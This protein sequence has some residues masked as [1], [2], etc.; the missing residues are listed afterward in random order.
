[1]SPKSHLFRITRVLKSHLSRL[2]AVCIGKIRCRQREK[3]SLKTFSREDFLSAFLCPERNNFSGLP[4]FAF[5][6]PS[7]PVLLCPSK[8]RQPS[9]ILY[10]GFLRFFGTFFLKSQKGCDFNFYNTPKTFRR[11]NI[12]TAV[13]KLDRFSR[14]KYEMEIHRKHL[15]DNGI[16]ILSAKENIHETPEGVLP[17]SLLEG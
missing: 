9:E 7:F 16:K 5:D 17:E 15:K 1:M 11:H 8:R 4:P 3:L 6:C 13:Y 10:I 12:K 2:F 14:N